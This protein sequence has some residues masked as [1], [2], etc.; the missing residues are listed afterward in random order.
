MKKIFTLIVMAVMAIA[1]K[2]ADVTIYVEATDAPYLY[3]WGGASNGDWPGTLM[4]ETATVQEKT[5][6]KK[7]FAATGAFNIIFNNGSGKQTKDI[8]NIVSDRYFTYDGTTGYTDVTE[9]YGGAIPDAEISGV[10]LAGNHTTPTWGEG[11]QA[12]QAVEDGTKYQITV[13]LTGITIEEDLWLFKFVA[14]SLS[15]FGYSKVTFDNQPTWLT[16]AMTDDNFSVDLE[17]IENRTF[18][19][20]LTWGG[21]KDPGENWTLTA[22]NGTAHIDA[23]T[24]ND[25]AVNQP[26]NLSGQRVN[27]NYRG[28]V[29]Q[30]GK[31]VMVK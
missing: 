6:W 13:D 18:T 14:N 21:G 16:Q 27:N 25:K 11:A 22:T 4:S 7:T 28:L 8:T 26:Y 10:L 20:M 19:F 23:I 24:T 1:A 31:K 15:W 17:G 5:F 2:A 9:Q 30:N 3:V 29:I 12:F